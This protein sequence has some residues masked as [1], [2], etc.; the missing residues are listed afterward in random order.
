[1]TT[2]A[3]EYQISDPRRRGTGLGPDGRES[4]GVGISKR[5]VMS[6]ELL[7]AVEAVTGPLAGC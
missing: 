3:G 1:M 2:P 6:A 4:R 7:A 5:V